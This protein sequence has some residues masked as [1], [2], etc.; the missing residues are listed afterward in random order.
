MARAYQKIS[1]DFNSAI[2]LTIIIAALESYSVYLLK[3]IFDKGFTASGYDALKF[4]CVQI[5]VVYFVKGW[6]SFSHSQILNHVSVKTIQAIQHRVFSHLLTL[7]MPFFSRNNSGQILAR[8]ISDCQ[9][10]SQIAINFITNTFKDV[11]TCASMFALI[12]YFSWRL[13]FVILI[14][15]P[16]GALAMKAIDKKVNKIERKSANASAALLSKIA[17]ALQNVKIIKSY[18]MERR[19]TGALRAMFDQL[20][21]LS[22]SRVKTT[23]II[24][25]LTDSLTGIILAIIIVYGGYQISNNSIT[26]GDFVAFLGAWVA[27]YKPLKSLLHFKT[28]LRAALVHAERVYEVIDAKSEI[29]DI[30]NAKKLDYVKGEIE[31][32]ALSFEYESGEKVLNNINLIIPS[33]STVALVGSSGGGKTT[34]ISLVPRFFEVSEGAV[35]I[36]GV[37]IREYSQASLRDKIA[38]VS[39]EVILFDDTI[40]NNIAYAR[41]E[42][43]VPS[44][45]EIKAAAKSANADNFIETL[46]Q[47]YDTIIG[48][49]GSRLSGGQKQRISIARAILKDA[50]ILLFDEATSALDTKS[51]R[52]VQAALD[53]MM[54]DR[55]AIVIAHRLSTIINAD[56]ICVLLNGEIIER[57]THEELLAKKGEYA[58]LYNMQFKEKEMG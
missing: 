25:P 19:E 5:F 44:I 45:D 8:I 11:I 54:K 29:V 2:A 3:P 28:Q 15:V 23:A 55:T 57:G 38:Y 14:F 27:M 49:K 40:A 46:P 4:L 1:N 39:Q 56:L 34:L 47:G 58:K 51:E 7:D 21:H 9:A 20:F 24:T 22:R 48:E 53:L 32:R 50:P 36:D 43:N 26:A 17:E 31:F 52:E 41:G 10:V 35:L 42:G 33:G 37:D 13:F 16:L 6:L 18:N 12:L 30:P